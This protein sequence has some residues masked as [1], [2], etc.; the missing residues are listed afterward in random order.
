MGTYNDKGAPPPGAM[1]V[2]RRRAI[3]P[4]DESQYGDRVPYVITVAEPNTRLSDR[5]VPPED[6][7]ERFVKRPGFKANA[8]SGR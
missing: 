3:D 8:D 7:F 6:M 2:A 1:I 5:A 4:N